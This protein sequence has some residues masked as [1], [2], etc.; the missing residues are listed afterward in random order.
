[1][2]RCTSSTSP[3]EE[4]RQRERSAQDPVKRLP[5]AVDDL[6]GLRAARWIRESTAGQ[7]DRYGPDAQRELA[8]RA[9]ARLGMTDTG[10]EWSAAQSGSTVAFGRA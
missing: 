10:L 4:G 3:G 2:R 5:A 9:I 7:F 1:V 8:S 6:S